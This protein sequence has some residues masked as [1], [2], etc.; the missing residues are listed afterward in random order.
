MVTGVDFSAAEAFTRIQRVLSTKGV[1][2]IFCGVSPDSDVGIALRSVGMWAEQESRVEVFANLNS[3]LEWTENEYLLQLYQS[4]FASRGAAPGVGTSILS[5]AQAPLLAHHVRELEGS[6]AIPTKNK[7]A[8]PLSYENLA[9]SPRNR[10]LYEAACTAIKTQPQVA[11]GPDTKSHARTTMQPTEHPSSHG[12]SGTRA[13]GPYQ[14]LLTTFRGYADA[15][16]PASFFATIAPY[17][18]RV[19]LRA[20]AQLWQPGDESDGFYLIERGMLK[21]VFVFAQEGFEMSETMM[22]GTVAGEMTFLSHQPRNATVTAEEET[23]LWRLDR[24]ALS[25]IPESETD[26]TR[27]HLSQILLRVSSDEQQALMGYLVS[28]LT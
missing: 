3:A 10:L 18:V 7:P 13:D 2:L 1:T 28:R 4:G 5:T 27:R 19:S 12:R 20:G 6:Q 15:A 14:L 26:A 22:P 9:T 11:V 17:F 24:A 23:I 16:L 21:A 8:H 25:R